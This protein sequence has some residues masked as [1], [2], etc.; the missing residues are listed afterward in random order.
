VHQNSSSQP[1]GNLGSVE[2]LAP[3]AFRAGD[4]WQRLDSEILYVE[5]VDWLWNATFA[6]ALTRCFPLLVDKQRWASS[7]RLIPRPSGL[8]D[9]SRMQNCLDAPELF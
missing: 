5:L 9:R 3:L 4:G 6:V 2:A 7:A 8:L 1:L